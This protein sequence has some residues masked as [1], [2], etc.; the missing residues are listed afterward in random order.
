M[1]L[2]AYKYRLYPTQEQKILL[3]KTFGCCRYVYNKCLAKKIELYQTKKKGISMFDLMKDVSIW[4]KSEEMSWLKE[5]NSQALQMSI[6]NMDG[7]F[8]NFFKRI[9]KF[10]KFKS[11]NKNKQNFSNPQYTRVNFEEGIIYIR[12]FK[13][14]IKTIF[15]REFLGKI[16]TST[17]SKTP[18]GKYF[19]SILVEE[20]GEYPIATK[21]QENRTLGIDLGIKSFLTDSNGKEVQNPK[22]LN[23]KLNAL[24]RESKKLSRKKKGS[25]NRNKQRIKV[26]VIHEKISNCRKDFL[27]KTSTSLVKNQDY[28]SIA[29]EDLNVASMI[30]E[31]KLSR[32]I[33][34]VGWGMFREFLAYKCKRYGKNLLVINRFAPSSKLCSCGFIHKDLKLSDREWDCPSCKTHNFRDK[35]AAQNIKHFAFC[36]QNTYNTL[37]GQELPEPAERQNACGV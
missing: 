35:L 8:T 3:N 20:E 28:D 23:K 1:T 9:G 15:D 16:K 6:R 21:A 12:K 27:H 2:N 36:E 25:N 5:V 33:A 18:S 26:A 7:A 19:I 22:H 32:H 34:D 31:K 24:R 30:K 14:G 10:P 4:K 37:V 11:K 17:V 13:E 29:I